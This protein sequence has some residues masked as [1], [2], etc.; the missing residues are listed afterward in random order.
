[1]KI[2]G[3]HLAA[4]KRFTRCGGTSWQTCGAGWRKLVRCGRLWDSGASAIT[5]KQSRDSRRYREEIY[6]QFHARNPPATAKR[7]D[8]NASSRVGGRPQGVVDD[9][10]RTKHCFS[11]SAT[12][13]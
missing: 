10:V 5:L 13:R 2:F 1:V 3:K 4:T 9:Q 11:W 8:G 6:D 12:F 7:I